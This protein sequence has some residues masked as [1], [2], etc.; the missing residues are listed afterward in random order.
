M[1]GDSPV[2]GS[3]K[4]SSISGDERSRS[5]D[6]LGE[7]VRSESVPALDVRAVGVRSPEKRRVGV[8]SLGETTIDV[9]AGEQMVNRWRDRVHDEGVCMLGETIDVSCSIEFM[10]TERKD[11]GRWN[12]GGTDAGTEGA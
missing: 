12:G 11:D 8:C 2:D 9:R 4:V 5:V 1:V 3:I 6:K 10:D 7:G